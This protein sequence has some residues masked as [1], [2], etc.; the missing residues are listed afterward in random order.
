MLFFAALAQTSPSL[1]NRLVSPRTSCWTASASGQRTELRTALSEQVTASSGRGFAWRTRRSP[2]FTTVKT[3][4]T[5]FCE[6]LNCGKLPLVSHFRVLLLLGA[7]AWKQGQGGAVLA[8]AA[9]RLSVGRCSPRPPVCFVPSE[10]HAHRTFFCSQSIH[11][12]METRLFVKDLAWT[13]LK[14]MF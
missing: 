5:R 13:C 1:S 11:G 12:N 14:I 6:V 7:F 9:F 10:T 8:A 3:K 4:I 2:H